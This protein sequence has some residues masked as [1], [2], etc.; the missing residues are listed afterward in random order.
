MAS[1]LYQSFIPINNKIRIR[2]P[3]V[4]EVIDHEDEYNSL[5]FSM[6]AMPIDMMVQLDDVG[7]D[8]SLIDE[9]DLFLLMFQN[10]K[11][12]DFS[13]IFDGFDLSHMELRVNPA[14]NMLFLK[15]DERDVVIDKLIHREIA[16]TLRKVNHLEKNIKKPGNEEGRKYMIEK[17]RKKLL[18][19]KKAD[20]NSQ[21]EELIV[22][23]VNTEQFSYTYESVR[24]LSLYQFY[25][26]V[27]QIIKKI[28]Y[29]NRM[30]GIY[31]GT[32]NAKEMSQDQLN[33]LTHK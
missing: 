28:D 32:V 1:L 20:F 8:F 5:V 15:D 12:E 31:A 25:E 26:S 13:M 27:Y 7:I 3:T 4:G 16:N 17:A 30:H 22:A 9:Y 6:T 19:K 14:A 11:Q 33:W 23:L 10:L 29:D 24:E 21:L 18:K 2:I